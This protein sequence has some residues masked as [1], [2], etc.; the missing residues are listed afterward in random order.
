MSQKDLICMDGI[1]LLM[2]FKKGVVNMKLFTIE[3]FDEEIKKIESLVDI[4][5]ENEFDLEDS[6]RI[7]LKNL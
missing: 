6:I 1:Y 4:E 5:I 7:L 2:R 3:L